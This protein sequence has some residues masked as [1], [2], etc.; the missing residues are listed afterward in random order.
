[1][2]IGDLSTDSVLEML[3]HLWKCFSITWSRL[4]SWALASGSL[5][6]LDP[7]PLLLP[8]WGCSPRWRWEPWCGSCPPPPPL[9]PSPCVPVLPSSAWKKQKH[10][11][12]FPH[13]C[14]SCGAQKVILER[15]LMVFFFSCKDIWDMRH[16]R[17]LLKGLL[18]G[19]GFSWRCPMVQIGLLILSCDLSLFLCFFVPLKIVCF[20]SAS[21]YLQPE[22]YSTITEF[23]LF[24]QLKRKNNLPKAIQRLKLHWPLEFCRA[25]FQCNTNCN[26]VTMHVMVYTVKPLRERWTNR[27][28]K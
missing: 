7:G 1:M 11:E 24:F 3:L 4:A 15:P 14:W 17:V 23:K 22:K 26:I 6:F 9:P 12:I 28:K 21:S 25:S 18:D 10:I 2:Y 20:P 27:E 5:V 13:I 16:S 8:Q 19:R